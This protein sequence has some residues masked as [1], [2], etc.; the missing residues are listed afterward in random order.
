[1]PIK[2]YLSLFVFFFVV[3]SLWGKFFYYNKD[4][5]NALL[6]VPTLNLLAEEGFLPDDIIESFGLENNIQITVTNYKTSEELLLKLKNQKYD[7]VSFKSFHAKEIINDL[8]R[9]SY[10][11]IKN[12]ESISADFKNSTYDPDNKFAIPLFWGVEKKSEAQSL[13]WVESI[14]I[15]KDSKY[16]KEA[17]TFLDYVLQ[18][19]VAVEVTRFKKV[20]STN[21]AIERSKNIESKLK[22][23]YLR[24]ISIK[25][26]AFGIRASF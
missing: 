1:M 9:I 4:N 10:S 21:K 7:L 3:G 11:E 22:P 20:A 24:K 2:K 14:G 6:Q 8:A 16:K 13:L 17:H 12:K 23:S 19:E 25:D 18:T 26:L 5:R 15:F